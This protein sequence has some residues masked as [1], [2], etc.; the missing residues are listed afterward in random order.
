MSNIF[1]RSSDSDSN[2]A[3]SGGEDDKLI[4][5]ESAKKLINVEDVPPH[6]Y[7]KVVPCS[8]C[9]QD[10]GLR[11]YHWLG[12]ISLPPKDVVCRS[13]YGCREVVVTTLL[14]CPQCMKTIPSYEGHYTDYKCGECKVSFFE[15]G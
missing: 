14:Q 9:D 15:V 12:F 11:Q 6:P 3:S 8:E 5:T 1:N 7:W 10:T 2:S 4:G 13:G